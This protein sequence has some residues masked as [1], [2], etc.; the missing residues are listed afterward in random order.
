[1]YQG[2]GL[3]QPCLGL[4]ERG[5][6]GGGTYLTS[7]ESIGEQRQGANNPGKKLPIEVYNSSEALQLPDD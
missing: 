3:A 5:F 6:H 2:K 4:S 7:L 1:M